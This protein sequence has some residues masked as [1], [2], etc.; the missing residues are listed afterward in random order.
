M[1]K[2][3]E[4]G[5]KNAVTKSLLTQVQSYTDVSNLLTSPWVDFGSG[6]WRVRWRF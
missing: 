6:D 1:S 5:N 4:R 2:K 3:Q